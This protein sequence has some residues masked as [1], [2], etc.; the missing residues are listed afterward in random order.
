M[1]TGLDACVGER[2]MAVQP[3]LE[4]EDYFLANYADGAFIA[5]QLAAFI[6][7]LGYSATANH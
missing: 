7:N 6:A 3:Y 5:T 2:L 1:D 4:G